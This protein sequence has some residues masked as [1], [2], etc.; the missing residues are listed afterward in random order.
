MKGNHGLTPSDADHRPARVGPLRSSRRLLVV[1]ARVL[2]FG[3]RLGVRA[4]AARFGRR[5][6]SAGALLGEELCALCEALGPTFIKLGQ[7]V[8]TRPD[9]L[10]PAVVGPLARLQDDV[11]PF[12][13]ADLPAILE[14]ELG[15]PTE[16]LFDALDIEPVA[17]A[18]IAQVHRARLLDGRDVA[19]KVRRP[20]IVEQVTCDLHVVG[21]LTRALAKL[22]PMRV[23]PLVE[24]AEELGGPIRQQLDLERE[25]QSLRRFREHFR[26]VEHITMPVLVDEL[27]TERVLTMEYLDG[28]EKVTSGRFSESERR[29]AALAGLRALYKMIFL[30][31][32][33]HADLHPGNVFLRQWGELVVLDM[34]LVAELTDDD[35]QDFVDF[36]FGLINDQG[37][38]CAR[39]VWDTALYREPNADR[40]AFTA[41]ICDLV[42]EHS[43]LKSH[44]FEVASFVYD[45]IEIQRRSGLRG[46]TKFIMTVLSMVVFDGICKQLYPECD[47]QGEA[48][49]FLIMAKYRHN[50]V[51][52]A[53]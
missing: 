42:A 44:E 26:G 46:S 2:L 17:A 52:A 34:G 36:F 12:D 30:D 45:L 31:G 7:I 48:R 15:R 13:A 39:I 11:A 16:E 6:R 18:S 9:L 38:V 1:V 23:V 14:E 53:V 28:L 8:S 3:V 37:E 21:T 24:L 20:G 40:A 32:F 41:A 10:P 29:T 25:A 35:L 4:L 43:R 5:R 19:L 22:P 50:A 51:A 27:C 47:F 49:G 33:I